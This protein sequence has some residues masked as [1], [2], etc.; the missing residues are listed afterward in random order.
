MRQRSHRHRLLAV[1][2]RGVEIAAPG[3][4]GLTW[5]NFTPATR[6]GYKAGDP[7][8]FALE[9]YADFGPH[10]SQSQQGD[11]VRHRPR[12]HPRHRLLGAQAHADSATCS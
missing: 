11:R 9:H 5:H 8:A 2:D 6:V 1:S 4:F 7:L 3:Q 12:T 10:P